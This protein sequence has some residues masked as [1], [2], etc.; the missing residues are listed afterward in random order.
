[1]DECLAGKVT[2]GGLHRGLADG[3]KDV[4]AEG[5]LG[6][7]GL[8]WLEAWLEDDCWAEGVVVSRVGSRIGWVAARMA[9]QRVG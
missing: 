3:C 5:R 7:F 1:M 2:A 6:G 9:A 8:G 4:C